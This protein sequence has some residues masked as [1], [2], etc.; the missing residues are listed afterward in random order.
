MQFICW[1]WEANLWPGSLILGMV[2]LHFLAFIFLRNSLSLS[3]ILWSSTM[4]VRWGIYNRCEISNLSFCHQ[5]SIDSAVWPLVHAA[6]LVYA[7]Q[8]FLS[9]WWQLPS[10]G[11]I[12]LLPGA[13][14][15]LCQPYCV[16]CKLAESNAHISICLFS[17]N[18]LDCYAEWD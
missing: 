17:E 7:S 2:C 1:K 5:S 14:R 12:F 18:A 6:E 10:R 9:R 15:S 3:S 13:L 16:V 8:L 11:S 4:S